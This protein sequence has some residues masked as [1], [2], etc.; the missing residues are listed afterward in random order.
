M[1]FPKTT[2]E[3]GHLLADD[4]IVCVRGR[5]DLREEPAKIVA[6]EIKRPELVLDGG[7]A[8]RI[9]LPAAQV[10]ERLV[11]DVK[12]VLLEHAGDSPVYLHIGE[13]VLRLPQQ[14]NVDS[15]NGLYAEL[16][17]VLGPNGLLA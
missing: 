2:A 12:R 5:L 6:V 10:T 17:V 9:N 1:V 8:L 3:Y 14:F 11:S 7:P 15:R 13:K 4:A 16:R